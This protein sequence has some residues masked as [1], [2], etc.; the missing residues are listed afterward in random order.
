MKIYPEN[1]IVLA[2]LAGYTDLPYRVSARRHGC[3]FAFTEMVD[4]GSLVFQN[5]KTLTFLER[6]P[7]EDWLGIQ[8]VGS[9][10]NILERAV[11]IINAYD[12]SVLDFNLGC[13][14]PKVVKKGEGAALGK[15][16]DEAVRAFEV[17]AKKSKIPV[18]A[19]LRILEES[20]PESTLYLLRKLQDAG[21]AAVTVHGRVMKAFYSGPVFH[22][23]IS[24][25]RQN[26]KIQ[27]VAN[28][29]VMDLKS[30]LAMKQ[31]TGCDSV[32]VA[33][34]AMG[35]PWIF[36]E[37]QDGGYKP[38]TVEE[39]I[40]EIEEHISHMLQ[41]YKTEDFVFRYSRKVI[42]DYLRG[43]GFP[44]TIRA[45]VSHIKTMENF[46]EFMKDVKKGPSDA[47]WKNLESPE[48]SKI[49]RFLSQNHSVISG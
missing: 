43:R 16:P 26:L 28:G 8:I 32:M 9:D 22:D 24:F 36:T 12:F 38:P 17:I 35:N 29:G 42:L 15:R 5:K 25:L 20:D 23:I 34:G 40:G 11:E 30:C 49:E 14:A 46:K 31:H 33:R 44:G 10:H 48:K 7:C 47:Y 18:T 37:L 13:P 45:M 41:F 27:V 19:K 4:A 39:F 3:R 2:P 1:S 21:A 6:H